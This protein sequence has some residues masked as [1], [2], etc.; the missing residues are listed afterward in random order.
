MYATHR[1]NLK[2]LRSALWAVLGAWILAALLLLMAAPVAAQEASPS[3]AMLRRA[4]ELGAADVFTSALSADI[5]GLD[6]AL[7]TDASSL[8]VAAQIYDTLVSFAPGSTVPQG[9]LALSWSSSSDG[10]T[11]IFDLRP[12]VKFHDGSPLDAAAV[13]YNVQRW[14]DP[15]HPF[16]QGEFV[17]FGAFFGGFKGDPDCVL[18]GVSAPSATQVQF[19]FTRRYSVL[20]TALAAG[21][22]GIASPAAIRSGS[23]DTAPVGSGPF[24]FLQHVTGQVR[25]GANADYWGTLPHV[26]DLN[27]PV[28]PDETDRLAALRSG[29]VH[30]AEISS[31]PVLAQIADANLKVL[32]RPS[33]NTGYL[34]INRAHGP[35]GN[36]LVRE[37]IAHAIDLKSLIGEHYKPGTQAATQ[38]VPPIVWGSDPAL[39]GYSYDPDLARNLLAEAGYAN[40]FAT[41]LAYRNVVRSYLPDPAGTANAIRADLLAVGIDATLAE[42]ESGAF[43]DKAGKGELDLFLLGWGA[44]YPHPLNFLG[45]VLCAGD[46]AFGARDVVLCDQLGAAQTEPS[47]FGELSAY[48][49]ASRRA[50]DTL[51]LLAL[52]HTRDALAVRADA[53]LLPSP[54]G[55]VYRDAF[56]TGAWTVTPSAGLSSTVAGGGVTTTIQIAPG[57]VTTD[58]VFVYT[59]V[60]PDPLASFPLYAFGGCAFSLEAF[61]GSRQVPLTPAVPI[62]LTVDYGGADLAAIDEESLVLRYWNGSQWSDEG[63]T[64]AARDLLLHRLTVTI[65]HLS[66]FALFG[67]YRHALLLPVVTH[68]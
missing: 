17:Y 9:G 68:P 64:V 39:D 50:H 47:F 3:D 62:T 16:H 32:W 56:F 66:D 57:A 33:T 65:D 60:Q 49:A 34:G 27:F 55:E 54:T 51:P 10:K 40:G 14:W 31:P 48:R 21:A 36:Q 13:V 23:L 24:R 8:L 19:V 22:F 37:A 28:I 63:I 53:A 41:T 20:P 7:H 46:K 26:G 59:P 29:A 5:E 43:L 35:L 25:L 4:V 45:P 12:G 67:Q 38:L 18:A 58:T 2:V 52:A 15:A 6:P 11:W 42:M 30:A 44:D 1:D 61:Q